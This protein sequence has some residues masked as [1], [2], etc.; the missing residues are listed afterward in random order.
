MTKAAWLLL[1]IAAC[2]GKP[3]GEVVAPSNPTTATT[4]TSTTTAPTS[5]ATAPDASLCGNR[6]D[7]Y[8]PVLLDAGHAAQRYGAGAVHFA[9]APSSQ[10][11]PIEVCGVRGEM[12]WLKTVTCA[13]GSNPY[14]ANPDDV[15]TG[16]TGLGGRCHTIIDLYPAKCP[17]ATY[18]IYMD[19]YMC[20]PGETFK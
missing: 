16:E 20:G 17:E 1:T 11:Q 5:T 14:G 4:P 2:G 9:D 18:Q 6:P 15:R 12:R 10:Q 3:G 8:G 19:L 7:E 13:D